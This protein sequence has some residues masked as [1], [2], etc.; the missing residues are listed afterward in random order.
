[1]YAQCNSS[2]IVIPGP[3]IVISKQKLG[4]VVVWIDIVSIIVIILF[5]KILKWR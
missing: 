4:M 5:A 2:T 1:M 3:N